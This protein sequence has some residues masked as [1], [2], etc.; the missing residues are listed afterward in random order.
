[1]RFWVPSIA[2]SGLTVYN[3][4]LF[5]AWRGKVLIGALRSQLI[6]VIDPETGAEERILER[7]HGRIRD[8]RTGPDGAVWFITDDR[9]GGIFRI[10][11]AGRD[12]A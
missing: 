3:G 9:N 12:P 7:T 6:A 1:V 2:P 8:V 5:P 10:T 11:P 4:D